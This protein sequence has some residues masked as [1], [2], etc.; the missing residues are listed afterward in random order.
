MFTPIFIIKYYVAIF[1]KQIAK[2]C[3][4]NL[5]DKIKLFKW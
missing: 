4:I 1:F 5:N 2:A 3:E